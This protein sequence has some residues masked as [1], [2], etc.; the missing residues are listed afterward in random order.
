MKYVKQCFINDIININNIP[1]SYIFEHI[2]ATCLLTERLILLTVAI[3]M[4]LFSWL[5]VG[6]QSTSLVKYINWLTYSGKYLKYDLNQL[7]T[8][9]NSML[10][11]AKCCKLCFFLSIF[12]LIFV[13]FSHTWLLL[14]KTTYSECPITFTFGS[15][16]YITVSRTLYLLPAWLPA[17]R[18]THNKSVLTFQ[19]Q[20]NLMKVQIT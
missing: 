9:K 16:T 7:I 6:A 2:Q 14:Y 20:N 19:N 17:K 5:R 1:S 10:P 15:K 3:P 18:Q 13:L 11:E 4:E 8:L 12:F